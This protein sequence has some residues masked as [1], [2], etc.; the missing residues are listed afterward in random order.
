MLVT[1]ADC[2]SDVS[3]AAQSCPK[4]G[5]P[6]TTDEVTELPSY[7]EMAIEG[8]RAALPVGIVL[9]VL[10]IVFGVLLS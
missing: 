1:C 10:I 5:R 7:G 6:M 9:F 4:C 3:D 8:M 2:G